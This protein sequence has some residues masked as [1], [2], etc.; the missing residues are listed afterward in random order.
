MDLGPI[1]IRPGRG[2]DLGHDRGDRAL[3]VVARRPPAIGDE[4]LPRGD[5][6]ARVDPVGR[7]VDRPARREPAGLV[8]PRDGEAEGLVDVVHAVAPGGAALVA[9]DERGLERAG[10]V[11]GPRAR[12]PAIVAARPRSPRRAPDRASRRGACES[13]SRRRGGGSSPRAVRRGSRSGGRRAGARRRWPPR[14]RPPSRPGR[15]A[16]RPGPTPSR[17]CGRARCA[18]ARSPCLTRVKPARY[19][20]RVKC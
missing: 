7:R 14:C 17:G 15:R 8:D 12:S 6:A 20:T 10:H 16:R 9:R 2:D 1:V 3:D 4:V 5:V 18:W 13:R 19:C 11:G